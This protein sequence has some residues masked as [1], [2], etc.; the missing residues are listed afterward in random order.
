MTAVIPPAYFRMLAAWFDTDD[1]LKEASPGAR[2]D[3]VQR[4]LR[5]FADLLDGAT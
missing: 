3:D 2:Q 1:E 5:R 4:D